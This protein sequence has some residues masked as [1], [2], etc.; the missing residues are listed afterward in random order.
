MTKPIQPATAVSF[1]G[2]AL[3][4][5]GGDCVYAIDQ[6]KRERWHL[7]LCAALQNALCLPELPNFLLP[8]YTATVD[9]W[10]DATSQELITVAE[11][12]PR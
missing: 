1:K 7:D 9:R 4:T 12:Y 3:F 6:H 8:C 11:A 2:L 5:P 10:V